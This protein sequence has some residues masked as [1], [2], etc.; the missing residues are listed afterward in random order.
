MPLLN[1][2]EL[3]RIYLPLLNELIDFG[4]QSLGR[5]SS[6]SLTTVMHGEVLRLGQPV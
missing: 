3:F 6:A 5:V 2:E 4:E 1:A